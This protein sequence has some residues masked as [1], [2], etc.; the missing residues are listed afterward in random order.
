MGRDDDD[1]PSWREIDKRRDGSSH[2]KQ[3]KREKK[4][5]PKDRWNIGRHKKAL[6]RLFLGDKGTV[7]HEKFYNKIHK[8]YGTPG[9]ITAIEKYLEK[10]GPPDDTSTLLLMLDS[11]DADIV[12]LTMEKLSSMHPDVSTREKDDI[13]R[14]LSLLALTDKSS[15]VKERAAEIVEEIRTRA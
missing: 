4:E 12:L 13:R 9:F 11:K 10:Y 6:D 5:A 8:T 3:E 2:T 1:R 15:E 14:K 7:E